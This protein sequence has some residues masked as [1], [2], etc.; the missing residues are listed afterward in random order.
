MA[1]PKPVVGEP[2]TIAENLQNAIGSFWNGW[3][4][5]VQI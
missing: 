2:V 5:E 1:I 3:D 4:I